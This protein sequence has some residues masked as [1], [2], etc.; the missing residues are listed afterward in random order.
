MRRNDRPRWYDMYRERG[1]ADAF[2]DWLTDYALDEVIYTFAHDLRHQIA[3]I[4][5]WAY[6]WLEETDWD[7]PPLA[8]ARPV[9]ELL[10]T[11]LFNAGKIEQIIDN[12]IDHYERADVDRSPGS[13]AHLALAKEALRACQA[14]RPMNQQVR[15]VNHQLR[16]HPQAGLL[17]L[18]AGDQILLLDSLTEPTEEY[19]KLLDGILDAIQRFCDY[20]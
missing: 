10:A 14:I 17:A 20:R 5:S 7:D 11:L 16:T 18:E 9:R 12:A 13:R 8:A 6:L 1:G 2:P 15:A 19:T 4:H 3:Y